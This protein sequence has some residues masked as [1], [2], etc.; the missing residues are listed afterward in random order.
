M[1]HQKM[2]SA[3]STPSPQ[4]PHAGGSSQLPSELLSSPLLPRKQPTFTC[5]ARLLLET[6]PARTRFLREQNQKSA[7]AL[8]VSA[9]LRQL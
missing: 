9:P 7:F 5:P 6:F 8:G 4:I 2:R 1:G 3:L